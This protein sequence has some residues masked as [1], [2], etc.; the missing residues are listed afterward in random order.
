MR[1]TVG[2]RAEPLPTPRAAGGNTKIR[3]HVMTYGLDRVLPSG[4][5]AFA[6]PKPR[7]VGFGQWRLLDSQT[8]LLLVEREL[9]PAND[10]IDE[11]P[12]A[13]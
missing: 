3:S 7:R 12:V 10:L 11:Y 13:L 8:R 9:R 5:G 2:G 1:L 6:G 4:N